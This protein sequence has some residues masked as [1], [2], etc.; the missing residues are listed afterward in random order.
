MLLEEAAKTR[1]FPIALKTHISEDRLLPS[2]LPLGCRFEDGTPFR[3]WQRPGSFD[4]HRS[5]YERS[6]NYQVREAGWPVRVLTIPRTLGLT[7][8]QKEE[9]YEKLAPYAIRFVWSPDKVS[10]AFLLRIILTIS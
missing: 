6:P 5:L 3:A 8:T 1:R 9:I 7:S 2:Q 4:R 10:C